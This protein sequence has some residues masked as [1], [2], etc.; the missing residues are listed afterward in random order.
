MKKLIT[1]LLF[2]SLTLANYSQGFFKPVDRNMFTPKDN[3]L[4]TLAIT[5]KWEF[6]PAIAISAVQLNWNKD[7]KQF[8]ASAFNSAGIGIGYQHFIELP[9]GSPFNNYGF[10]GILLLGADDILN[11]TVPTIS[12]AITGSFLQY[13]NIGALYNF[14]NKS[15]GILTGVSLKF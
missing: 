15:F 13:V 11:P 9:D 1:I 3:A 10:N 2:A 4:K 5:Q 8:D 7:K 6:R 12:F 14:T